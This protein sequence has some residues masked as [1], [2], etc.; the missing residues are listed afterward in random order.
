MNVN[1]KKIYYAC[2]KDRGWKHLTY[3]FKYQFVN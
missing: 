1:E 3:Y 2:T